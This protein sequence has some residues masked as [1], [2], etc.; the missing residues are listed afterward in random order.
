MSDRKQQ[1]LR[2]LCRLREMNVEQ[3]RAEHLAAQADLEAKRDR[4]EDTQRRIAALD[5]W[6][7]GQLS[8]GAPLLPEVLR[9]AQLFRGVEKQTLESQRAQQDHSQAL[10][11][12]AHGVLR[13]QFEELSAM[14]RLAARHRQALDHEELRHSY[15]ELDEAGAQS[16]NLETKE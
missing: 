15:V 1:R 13:H 2:V 9:Q 14:E 7:V 16:K 3:A 10:T 12:T 4:A 5:E 8:G 11:E 6:A